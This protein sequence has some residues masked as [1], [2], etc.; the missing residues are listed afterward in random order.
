VEIVS[1]SLIEL[2]LFLAYMAT[3]VVLTLVY[4]VIYMWVTP[5]S[6]IALIRQNNVAASLAFT[7]SL[8]GFSLPLASAMSS[9]AALVDVVVWGLVALVVQIAI[10]FL[11]C[12]PMPKIS[13]RIEDG[14]IAA[15]LW[16]GA[17]SLTGGI[18]NAA[19]MTS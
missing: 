12:L 6:E 16:L 10:F 13:K 2:P 11:V 17:A 8:V 9:S 3:A 4:T 19:S 7:G 5:H 14:E 1:A 18:L 15:G